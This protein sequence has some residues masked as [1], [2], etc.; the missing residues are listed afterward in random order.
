MLI[1]DLEQMRESE[2]ENKALVYSQFTRYLD[3]VAH[4]LSWKGCYSANK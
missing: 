3:M 4:I 1:D 2:P